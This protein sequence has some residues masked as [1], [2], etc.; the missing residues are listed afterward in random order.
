MSR[1]TLLLVT[2]SFEIILLCQNYIRIY[3]ILKLKF[4]ITQTNLDEEMFNIK[5]VGLNETTTLLFITF[6]FEIIY[7]PKILFE[8]LMYRSSHK[9]Y[10]QAQFFFLISR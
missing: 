9:S 5:I 6:S 1:T 7:S 2:F 4:K 3:Q 10:E 8:V